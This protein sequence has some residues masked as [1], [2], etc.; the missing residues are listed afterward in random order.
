[1][2]DSEKVE[3]I[4]AEEAP[5]DT[6]DAVAELKKTITVDTIHND[7]G[8]KVLANYT[9][10]ETWTEQEEKKV[11]RRIDRRLLP[12]LCATYGL[13]V[14]CLR[15]RQ[16]NEKS[17]ADSRLRFV[18]QYYDKAMLSQAV[19]I[20]T[21]TSPSGCGRPELIVSTGSLRPSHRPGTRNRESLFL[22]SRHLLPWLLRWCLSR[23]RHGPALSDR[24][25]G[26]GDCV[27]LGHLSDGHCCLPC[28]L[29]KIHT[30]SHLLV[31]SVIV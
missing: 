13:Q 11:Q 25:S 7:E 18:T 16:H 31:C 22:F 30:D 23:H 8:M 21:I 27:C 3:H 26:F 2:A 5:R 10:D 20:R 4:Q 6:A 1:M 14:R 29:F 17:G 19:C 15:P 9:G 28:E 24:T 12:I